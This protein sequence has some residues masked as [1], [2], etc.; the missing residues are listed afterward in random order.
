M[1]LL[2]IT[3]LLLLWAATTCV[4]RWLGTERVVQAGGIDVRQEQECPSPFWQ[5]LLGSKSPY[6][7]PETSRTD[8]NSEAPIANLSHFTLERSFLLARHCSRYP[9]KEACVQGLED[10]LG[11]LPG[12]DKQRRWMQ[13]DLKSFSGKYGQCSACGLAELRGIG[14]RFWRGGVGLSGRS[15]QVQWSSTYV[16]RTVDSAHHWRKGLLSG[17]QA[18]FSPAGGPKVVARCEDDPYGFSQLRFFDTC[19]RYVDYNRREAKLPAK[20][21]AQ[22]EVRLPL[23]GRQL[24]L[25]MG[26]SWPLALAVEANRARDLALS[27][28]QLC[29][30][31]VDTGSFQPG[32]VNGGVGRWCALLEEEDVAV[33][34]VGGQLEQC[35]KNGPCGPS[36][37]WLQACPLLRTFQAFLASGTS[38]LP[39]RSSDRALLVEAFFAHAETLGPFLVHGAKLRPCNIVL[40][41]SL[42]LAEKWRLRRLLGICGAERAA[43]GMARERRLSR[44]SSG[45]PRSSHFCA[46]ERGRRLRPCGVGGALRLDDLPRSQGGEEERQGTWQTVNSGYP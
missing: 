18:R 27:V 40:K 41:P 34:S 2:S 20:L 6:V 7:P 23:I 42:R 24:L 9:V 5:D 45:C 1:S 15:L 16:P 21:W 12:L 39:G 25:R 10:A 46:S 44:D 4:V 43:Y 35:Y 3:T 32:T 13:D 28:Y 19:A 17:G 38:D 36:I 11:D 22:E 37:G 31:E 26:L 30:A 33:L 29:Q 8:D 14:R